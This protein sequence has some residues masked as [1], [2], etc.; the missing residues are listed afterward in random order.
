[1]AQ[2]L[3]ISFFY[4]YAVLGKIIKPQHFILVIFSRVPASNPCL[5]H[6]ALTY[7][8]FKHIKGNKPKG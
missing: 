1:M 3:E 2:K 6:S 4:Y 8:S 5:S 7:E